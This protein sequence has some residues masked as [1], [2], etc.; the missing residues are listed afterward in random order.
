MFKAAIVLLWRPS[1]RRWLK[2]QWS[3]PLRYT[4]TR[5]K[6]H[7][8][9]PACCWLISAQLAHPNVCIKMREGGDTI[10]WQALEPGSWKERCL[11]F[12]LDRCR[13]FVWM[14]WNKH[15]PLESTGK[16]LIW[17]T[18]MEKIM[19]E[20][21][22]DSESQIKCKLHSP[23]LVIDDLSKLTYSWVGLPL[24][25]NTTAS[26]RCRFLVINYLLSV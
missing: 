19:V 10:S 16:R 20:N 21:G 8:S 5:Q 23:A 7:T 2:E 18:P 26:D 25:E 4:T 11:R 15:S 1:L 12:S 13:A 17:R 14:Q 3:T 9:P 6:L 22:L 24:R